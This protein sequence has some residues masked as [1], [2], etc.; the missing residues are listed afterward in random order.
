M[1]NDAGTAP[2]PLLAHPDHRYHELCVA[3]V[4]EETP[5][6]HSIVF[7]IPMH[8]T[9]IFRY[10]AGQF[11]TLRLPYQGKALVRCYSLA[12]S[13]DCET[14]HKVTV[15]RIADGRISNWINDHL[16]AGDR[17]EVLPPGGLFTLNAGDNPLLLFAG[18]SGITPVI[19][20]IKSALVTTWR[21]IKLVYAN[22]D[23]T[24]VIFRAELDGLAAANPSR[25]EIAYRLDV[26][27]GFLRVEDVNAYVRGHTDAECYLCG[28]GPF[29]EI[30]E[31][32]LIAAG[33]AADRIH[34][35]KF[36][37]PPDPGDAATEH[38]LEAA[39][40]AGKETPEFLT[41]GLD[42]REERVAY[43]RGQTVLVA[44]QQAGLQPPFSCTEGFCGCC[45]AK[46]TAGQVRMIN[47]DFLSDREV[48]EGWV[49]TC[50]SVPVTGSCS[51]KYPD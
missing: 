6:A 36:L 34:I 35:E 51:V 3:R 12:S 49:L 10:R 45:M 38:A 4:I 1:A 48:A 31:R 32:G 20:L 19:S 26:A 11:L 25:L 8:L 9:E 29:M 22:R 47:N 33:V 21:R 37:S 50:Q 39:A 44:C 14:E 24:S 28:P 2:D 27:D 18:G 17:V 43:R 40:L 7:E 5:D 13:P 16:R 23:Q 46:L 41:V 42:G 30:T 15:K